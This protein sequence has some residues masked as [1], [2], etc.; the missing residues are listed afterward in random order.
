VRDDR[1]LTMIISDIL[2]DIPVKFTII[3]L[4]H[5]ITL[6]FPLTIRPAER[7]VS[8]KIKMSWPGLVVQSLS[9]KLRKKYNV[10]ESINGVAVNI[11]E[12]GTASFYAGFQSGDVIIKINN[13]EINTMMDYYRNL[14]D[15]SFEKLEIM[16]IRNSNEEIVTL[17]RQ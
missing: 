13:S 5:T 11:V 17:S 15:K 9:K 7:L 14:N 1:H 12:K 6:S 8:N 2:P 16:V 10:P 4:G 3:R